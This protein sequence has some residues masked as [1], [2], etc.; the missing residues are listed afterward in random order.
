MTG[1][2]TCAL[3]ILATTD[4][5]IYNGPAGSSRRT[6]DTMMRSELGHLGEFFLVLEDLCKQTGNL[7]AYNEVVR[8]IKSGC[9]EKLR[10]DLT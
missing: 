9:K 6:S 4:N 8:Q 10:F 5:L 2:Q 3:P 7:Q 1:V